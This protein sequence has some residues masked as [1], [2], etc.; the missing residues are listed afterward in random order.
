LGCSPNKIP[1]LQQVRCETP[2][3]RQIKLNGCSDTK[4]DCQN[5]CK[6]KSDANIQGMNPNAKKVGGAI[7]AK[8]QSP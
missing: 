6:K 8:P 3:G 5:Q 1:L 2:L 4:A 7:A